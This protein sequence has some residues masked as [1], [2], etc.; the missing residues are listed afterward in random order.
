M[1]LSTVALSQTTYQSE[2]TTIYDWDGE[3]YEVVNS[4][5]EVVTF[6][7]YKEY[8]AINV[9]KDEAMFTWWVPIPDTN[10]DTDC[11]MT[12]GDRSKV[13]LWYE[14]GI[15]MFYVYPDSTGRYTRAIELYGVKVVE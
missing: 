5:E 8:I 1:F 7:T 6:T 11:Y 13:C 4:Y 2:Y 10:P 14:L 9:S 12:E 3:K 15:T